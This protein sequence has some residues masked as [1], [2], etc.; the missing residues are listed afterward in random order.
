MKGKMPQEKLE[1]RLVRLSEGEVPI[2]GPLREIIRFYQDV[3]AAYRGKYSNL[4]VV[5]DGSYDD[6]PQEFVIYGDRLETEVE[7]Q[8]RK[9]RARIRQVKAL[10]ATKK[11]IADLQAE[12]EVAERLLARKE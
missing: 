11:R 2:V 5:D 1:E 3:E 8:E 12:V 10:A 7:L 9:Q 6:D 4:R